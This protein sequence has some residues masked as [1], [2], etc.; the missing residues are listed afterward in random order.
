MVVTQG[1]RVECPFGGEMI[2]CDKSNMRF[3]IWDKNGEIQEFYYERDD[4]GK[5]IL[6]TRR[7]RDE[8]ETLE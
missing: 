8:D 3:R 5:I 2:N 1:N 6:K 7:Y 4:D